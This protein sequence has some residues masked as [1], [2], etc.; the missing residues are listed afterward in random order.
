MSGPCLRLRSQSC[1]AITRLQRLFFW[2]EGQGLSHSL[3]QDLGFM[4]YPTY[5][6]E[7]TQAVFPSRQALLDYE[8]ALQ[9]AAIVDDALEVSSQLNPFVMNLHGFVKQ[10]FW[11]G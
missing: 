1:E 3:V 8:E 5:K 6:V 10:Y 7:R 11:Y 4:R 2:N 9:L